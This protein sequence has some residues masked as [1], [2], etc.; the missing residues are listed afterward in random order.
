MVCKG[1]QISKCTG[2]CKVA[3]GSKRKFC[4]KRLNTLRKR[5]VVDPKACNLKSASACK[6]DPLCTYAKGSKRSFCRKNRSVRRKYNK[7]R[8]STMRRSA[9]ANASRKRKTVA[10]RFFSLF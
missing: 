8:K 6:Q 3:K 7:G 1:K 10:R 4:R 5:R 2:P 9:G